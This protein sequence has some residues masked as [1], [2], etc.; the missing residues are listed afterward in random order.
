MAS[1]LYFRLVQISGAVFAS[2]VSYLIPLVALL[3]GLVDG[4]NFYLV[5]LLGMT[6][7]LG[8]VYL[9][10]RGTQIEKVK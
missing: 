2:M 6:L 10:R 9:T 3:W 5:Y 4:E 1:V 7:I 8:G